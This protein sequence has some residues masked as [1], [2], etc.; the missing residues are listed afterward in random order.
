MKECLRKVL[1]ADRYEW[2][3][4]DRPKLRVVVSAI[5]RMSAASAR[6]YFRDEYLPFVERRLIEPSAKDTRLAHWVLRCA[7]QDMSVSMT[8]CSNGLHFE[9]VFARDIM[10]ADELRKVGVM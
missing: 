2:Q 3:S 6:V 7:V 8:Y 4:F 10:T 9:T 5:P 1:L